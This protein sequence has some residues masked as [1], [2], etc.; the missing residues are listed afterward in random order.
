MWPSNAL[1]HSLLP[2]VA[3]HLVCNPPSPAPCRLFENWIKGRYQLLSHPSRKIKSFHYYQQGWRFIHFDFISNL[4]EHQGKEKESTS[5]VF[6][7]SLS[8]CHSFCLLHP[9]VSFEI[10]PCLSFS[11]Y[12]GL[13]LQLISLHNQTV[14]SAPFSTLGQPPSHIPYRCHPPGCTFNFIS[15]PLGGVHAE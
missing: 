3:V 13:S 4:R 1:H 6:S 2:P 5:F 12:L 14:P 10:S 7:A 8:H 9:W 15:A 11:V